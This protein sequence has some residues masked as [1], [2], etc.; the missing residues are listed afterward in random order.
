MVVVRGVGKIRPV[1]NTPE[2]CP[3]YV[4]ES[5]KSGV[6]TLARD[7]IVPAMGKRRSH[8][9]R[10]MVRDPC[11]GVLSATGVSLV[12]GILTTENTGPTDRGHEKTERSPSDPGVE[13]ARE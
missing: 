10:S 2:N 11:G 1:E 13:T 6:D 5:T 3:Y 4:R 9:G 12:R 8:G 7:N